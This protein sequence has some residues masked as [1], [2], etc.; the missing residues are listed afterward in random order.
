[1]LKEIG[2]E[3]WEADLS[4]EGKPLIEKTQQYLL[5]GRTALDFI[6][7]DIKMT[8]QESNTVY[9][10][11]YCCHT[12]I[13]PFLD[14]GVA[15]EFYE[16]SFENGIY[17][18]EMNFETQCNI[19][20]IM[21][22]F[23]YCNEVVGH[24]IKKFQDRGKTIIEDATHSWFSDSLYSIRS[25]YVFASFRKWTGLPCGAVAIKR[26]ES[27]YTQVPSDTNH[28]YLLMRQQATK[29]KKQYIEEG[30]GQK[31]NFLKLF[32]QAE[33]L[34][35]NDYQNYN[36]LEEYGD[37]LLRLNGELIRRKRQVNA[38]H[39]I[40]GIKNCKSL[41]FIV[42]TDKDVPLFVPIIVR[43]GMRN[44]LQQ[45]LINNDIYCPIHW[46]LSTLHK[47]KNTYLYKNSLSLVCDQRYTLEDMEHI[48]LL[49]ND[50]CGR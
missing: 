40:K 29:M 1:M 31:E 19:V 18:Y 14:N 32:S 26:N 43:N 47:I 15:V 34:L 7:K 49:I 13:Q 45:Y 30:I 28:R 16:V 48:A 23:G 25:D 37:V 22:Y 50:F 11:S 38:K 2:S 3:F 9:M 36:T 39:L 24:V 5:T 27:F 41:E 33:K 44:E 46:P 42:G 35:E 4:K 17:K 20:L 10:P 8:K 21:Q 12:M 6:I